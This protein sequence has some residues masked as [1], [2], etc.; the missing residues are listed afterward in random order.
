[1]PK[2]PEKEVSLKEAMDIASENHKLGNLQKARFIYEKVL[3]KNQ[4]S[5][6]A[7]HLLGLIDYQEGSHQK[8]IE[9]IKKA[10][11]ITSDIA[12]FHNNLGMVYDSIKKEEESAE[13]FKKALKINSRYDKAYLAHYN[14]GIF[15]KDKGE[16]NEALNHYNKSIELN[17]D[18]AEAHWNKALVLLQLGSL[19]EGFK[20]FEYRFKKSIPTDSRIFSKPKWDGSSLKN[21]KL[22]IVSEQGLG[23][24][25]QFIRYLPLIK[26]EN[27]K[28]ILECK[29]E[30]GELF[31]NI[32]S[33]DEFIEKKKGVPNAEFDFYIHLMSLPLIFKTGLD[34]IP[35][36][37]PYIKANHYL[38]NK[39]KTITDTDKFKI[40][41]VWAG[42]PNHEN[43]KNRSTTPD[44]F[45]VLKE[46]SGV[47]LFSLQK[48]ISPNQ[49]ELDCSEI[50]GLDK[51]M[52]DFADTSAI[53]ENLDLIISVDTSIAHLA[54]AMNKPVWTLLS[55]ISDWRWLL[56]RD[57]S[58]WYPSMRLFRQKELGDWNS[59]MKEVGKE[60]KIL[61][62]KQLNTPQA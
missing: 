57:D 45:K 59:L 56:N 37:V 17:P 32:S 46:I 20:E 50:I 5:A 47:E 12:I 26:K 55:K 48:D 62:A 9:K 19:E 61:L 21:K 34:N 58:P 36:E 1:M 41:I 16:I 28:I 11:Q 22:L 3:E 13:C 35:N 39:F 33:I 38:A 44:K 40:G 25:I 54:G 29:K 51:N 15:H 49:L 2:E 31:K 52:D 42:N 14:L 60:L 4:C 27:T 30:L 10:I 23:D 7:L 43:D 18:F 53:M 24:S 6:D 8:A